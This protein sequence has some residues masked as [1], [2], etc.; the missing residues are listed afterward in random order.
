MKMINLW[1]LTTISNIEFTNDINKLLELIKKGEA[2]FLK[3]IDSY[4]AS[5]PANSIF[6]SV[7]AKK[8]VGINYVSDEHPILISN[9]DLLSHVISPKFYKEHEKEIKEAY[10]Y[11]YEH[12]DKDYI[13]VPPYAFSSELIDVIVKKKIQLVDFRDIDLP[14]EDIKKLRDNLISANVLKDG[15]ATEI[16]NNKIISH[17]TL[18]DLE[19]KNK[20]LISMENLLNLNL[21]N[22]T[23]FKD[24]KK[25]NI[26]IEILVKDTIDDEELYY[27]LIKDFIT[28]LDKT[29]KHF[30]IDIYVQNRSLFQKVFNGD[31]FNNIDLYINNDVYKYQYE[32]YLEEEKKLDELIEPIKNSNLS[33]LEKFIAIYNVVKNFKPYK[34]SPDQLEESRY[35]RYILNNEYMVCVGYAKLLKILCEKVG[36]KVI[37]L[38]M[39]VDISYDE[40]KSMTTIPVEY[41]GH[42]RCMV[43]IDDDKYGVHGLYIT[44]P[45]WDNELSENR[46]NHALMTAGKITTGKRMIFYNMNEPIMDINTFEDFNMEVN[47]LLRRYVEDIKQTNKIDLYG[48]FTFQEQVRMEKDKKLEEEMTNKAILLTAYKKVINA[49]LKPIPV[50]DNVIEFNIKLDKC[51]TEEDFINLLTD[52]GNYLLTRTNQPISNETIIQASVNGTT[53]LKGLNEEEREI[54]YQRTR[55]EFYDREEKQFPYMVDEANNLGWK[56]R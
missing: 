49:I 41:G 6:E 50:D 39:E 19:E 14:E 20:L 1:E 36:I 37:N 54:E 28:C 8:G 11:Y 45:T 12:I 9:N 27:K 25:D 55:K 33:P 48:F 2:S 46:L 3:I 26:K 15:T 53:I 51:K 44:D 4:D 56:E 52:I 21:N 30:T 5:R 22:V 40:D 10:C 47:Y 18:E 17:Y 13:S 31:R 42:A 23:Y 38:S 35:L 29:G 7:F 43:S 16:S 32:E 24:I 34:E